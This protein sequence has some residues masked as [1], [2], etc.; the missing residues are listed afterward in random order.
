MTSVSISEEIQAS[1]SR[2][3]K[4]VR[5]FGAI[6]DWLPA[7]E[8]SEADGDSVGAIRRLALAGG[9]IADER[10][11]AFDDAGRTYAY[12]VVDSTLPMTGYRATIRVEEKGP[13]ACTLHWSSTFEP[14]GVPEDEMAGMI[15]GSYQGGV[16][17]LRALTAD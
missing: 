17:S 9:A 13:D 10:L 12:S 7:A 3:W 11:E 4:L 8:A 16:E 1:A 2:V 14:V 15:Q 5:N 6:A